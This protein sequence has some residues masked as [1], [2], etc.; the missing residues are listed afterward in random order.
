MKNT[1]ISLLLILLTLGAVSC[2][3]ESPGTPTILTRDPTYQDVRIS[4]IAPIDVSDISYRHIDAEVTN[5][6]TGDKKEIRQYEIEGDKI[7]TMLT[8]GQYMFSIRAQADFLRVEGSQ[9]KSTL[10][11]EISFTVEPDKPAEAE[12]KFM[13]KPSSS[14]FVIEEIYIAGSIF[15]SRVPYNEDKYMII[16]NNSDEVLY[17]DGLAFWESEF[18]PIDKVDYEPNIIDKAVAVKAFYVIPGSGKEHPVAPGK[19]IIVCESAFDHTTICKD[20]VDL[21]KA[22]FEWYDP[23]VAVMAESINNPEVTDMINYFS[24]SPLAWSLDNKGATVFGL[25]YPPVSQ[26]EYLRDYVYNYSYKRIVLGLGEVEYKNNF[27]MKVPNEWIVD[28][29]AVSMPKNHEWLPISPKLETGWTWVSKFV[30]DAPDEDRYGYGIRRK[31]EPTKPGERK[32]LVDTNNSTNDFLPKVP[33]SLKTR[34]ISDYK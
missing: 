11:S 28:C 16:T 2:T 4:L 3:K 33:P 21:S 10:T 31:Q 32:R 25:A 30:G 5:V 19:S 12:V 22:D 7:H 14:N 18:Q 1:L 20:A 26:E 15:P 24:A 34:P 8:P 9:A 17:A 13:Y 6:Q 29:V 27:A 23:T